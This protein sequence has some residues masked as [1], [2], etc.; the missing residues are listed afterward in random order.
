[1]QRFIGISIGDLNGIGPE[2]IC[3]SLGEIHDM[4]IFSPVIFAHPSILQWYAE[5]ADF[6]LPE[7]IETDIY[8]LK[9]GFIN[10]IPL[11]CVVPNIIP[12][13]T[14]EKSARY[15]QQ[16][17]K[18]ATEAVLQ[19][20]THAVVTAPIS[21]EAMSLTGF[22]F[23]GHT[24]YLASLCGKNHE[25]LMVLAN[26]TIRVAL[27][28]VH[29][30]VRN[31]ADKIT[32]KHVYKVGNLFKN[33]LN[34][35]FGLENPKI[36]VLGL[37]P[38]AGD[39]GVLGMEEKEHI[40]PA[41]RALNALGNNFEGPF[42]ADGFF[43]SGMWK[44]YDGILA[45]YHDQGLIPFKTLAFHSGVNITCNLPIVRTSPDHGTGFSIAGKGIA[46]TQSFIEAYKAAQTIILNRGKIQ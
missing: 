5:R 34:K 22:K 32:Q 40:E 1:M 39:G 19:G 36:A 43:G 13:K 21:K 35:D 20:K 25:S 44:S 8:H 37:N 29:I 4:G 33:A 9:S 31:I 27:V 23:P 15:A 14:D 30:P 18:A 46:D 38:H 16:S 2:I 28:T 45:M 26:D 12:G 3:K 10:A 17:I 6:T 41:I 7:I 11:D 24:E 42:A